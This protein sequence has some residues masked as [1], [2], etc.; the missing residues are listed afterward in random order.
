[1]VWKKKSYE[2]VVCFSLANDLVV[3]KYTNVEEMLNNGDK[4]HHIF[5]VMQWHNSNERP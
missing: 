5:K 2:I 3:I 1:M 4:L